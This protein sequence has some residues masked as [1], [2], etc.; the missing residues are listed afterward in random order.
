MPIINP[1]TQAGIIGKIIEDAFTD[2]DSINSRHQRR[3]WNRLKS[4]LSK[5]ALDLSPTGMIRPTG[6]N[7][8]KV[9]IIL[10]ILDRT[11]ANKAYLGS[12]EKIIGAYELIE[13]SNRE[14]YE[15]L[16]SGFID[17]PAYRE[18]RSIEIDRTLLAVAQKP[19]R[20]ALF[21]PI[22]TLLTQHTTSGGEFFELVDLLTR[23]LLDQKNADG[24]IVRLGYLR[25]YHWRKRITRDSLFGYN[26]AYNETVANLGQMNWFYY[27][28]GLVEASRD[29]CRN[30]N[31]KYWHRRE[32]ESWASI[33]KGKWP[34]KMPDTNERTIFTLLGG[35]NCRHSLLPVTQD[36]V[37]DED[38]D[39]AIKLGFM[40]KTEIVTNA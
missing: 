1:R 19:F 33:P 10:K 16:L 17:R 28:G 25:N 15:Q 39:R 7:L 21:N 32:I 40:A 29:F 27:S 11:I 31:E 6:S 9:A 8:R 23:N 38:I 18:L 36:R 20:E 3:V 12:I 5:Y 14:Y 2:W 22:R 26:R 24:D 30:R 13:K 4:L 34:E 37:P 35:W